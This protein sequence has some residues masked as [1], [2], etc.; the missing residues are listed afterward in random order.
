LQEVARK[1]DVTRERVRQIEERALGKL[2][3]HYPASELAGIYPYP[4][5]TKKKK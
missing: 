5:N 3:W 2:L 4:Q 1:L